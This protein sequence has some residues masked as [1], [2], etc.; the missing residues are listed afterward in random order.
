MAR[1]VV[2]AKRADFQA[3]AAKYGIDPVT[4]RLI[5]N[6]D[7][8]NDEDIRQYLEGTLDDLPSPHLLKDA[9]RAAEIL[10]QKI[11]EG[12][13]IRILG[14]YDIDGVSATFILKKSLDHAGAAVDWYIPDR[15]LDGYGIH[16]HLI[17]RAIED[18]VD[19]IITCD[20]GIAAFSEITRAKKAGITV[21][22]TD[23]H[24]VPYEEADGNRKYIV[25]PADAVVN[26]KQID[27]LY[28]N[29]GI[30]GAVVALK[31]MQVLYDRM[32]L[33]KQVLDRL[34]EVAAIATVGDIMELQGENR[35]L[36]REGLKR[37]PRTENKGLRSLL[38]VCGLEDSRITAYHIGFVLGPCINAS[39]RLD[40]AARSLALLDAETSDEAEKLAGD[41][42]NMN[43]SRKA[44]TEEGTELAIQMVEEKGLL[45]DKVLVIFLP[46]CHESLAGII[47]GRI[48]E[49]YY[50]PAFI[51]TRGQDSAKGSGRSIEGYS[52]YD[53]MT[54]C[55]DLFLQFGGHA[56]AAGLS[57][58]E[59]KIG[60]FR[61]R[62]NEQC[63][64]TEELLTPKTVI[65]A[66]VPLGYLSRKL[67][68]EIG[69]LEPF[70]KGNTRPVFARK[71]L[72]ALWPRIVGKNRNVV[73]MKLEEPD[74][75]T[76]DA[77]YFGDALAFMEAVQEGS[78]LAVTYYP[79][80]NS[81]RGAE[82][83]QV[84]ITDFVVNN[85]KK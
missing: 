7:I 19:T 11:T 61:R 52:M 82:S 35:I 12:K 65:D 14:D 15:V 36:V 16:D 37:L 26:P 44:L 43:A 1:W 42:F 38:R 53:E 21:I 59:D 69:M 48:R 63:A 41:L 9:D 39:G 71:N 13:K 23:H 33:D 54:K 75:F 22:V 17:D 46:E 60:E 4:A 2:S 77:V 68:Q 10:E 29:S 81:Y 31:T 66:A 40:T 6:R 73:K 62:I 32:G 24:E 20:N 67:I 55:S 30:C 28:P 8:I 72:R 57:I 49:K 34:T 5:R 80:I 45:K 84:I 85:D 18:R 74:G 78:P 51:L 50:R 25:P 27:C 83:I 56:M 3:I 70:G 79:E 47:A 58:D 64:L 76:I